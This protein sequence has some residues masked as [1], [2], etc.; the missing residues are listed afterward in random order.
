MGNGAPFS[1]DVN[2][3]E[4]MYEEIID[5]RVR[6]IVISVARTKQYYKNQCTTVQEFY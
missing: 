1:Y 3:K 6:S 5:T 4:F 2:N